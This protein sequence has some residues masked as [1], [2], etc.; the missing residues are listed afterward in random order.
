MTFNEVFLTRHLAQEF[1]R[2]EFLTALAS[3]ALMAISKTQREWVLRRDNKK[4]QVRGFHGITCDPK[5]PEADHIIPQRWGKEVYGMTEEEFDTPLNL[6]TLCRNHHR[7]HPKSKHPDARE[8]WWNY[9]ENKNGF[10]TIFVD[11]EKQC[12]ASSPYWDTS[13]DPIESEIALQN[14]IVYQR[15][16]PEDPFPPHGKQR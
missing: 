7:G 8:A 14:T 1:L 13:F 2:P 10:D 11:R 12:D 3:A 15:E 16:H 4:C 9:R 5:H 6:L